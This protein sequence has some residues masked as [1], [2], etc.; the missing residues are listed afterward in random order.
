MITNAGLNHALNT[1]FTAGTP[2]TSWF[3]GL[4]DDAAFDELAETDTM[5]S[6]AGWT[7]NT[8][9]SQATRPAFSPST[10]TAEFVSNENPAEFTMTALKSLAGM[11]LTSV[12]TKGGTTGVLEL[13]IEFDT[14]QTVPIGETLKVYLE[15]EAGDG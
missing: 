6:H 11:F 5:G 14:V 1:E 9:Y 8:N 15:V 12:N 7:E 3:I 4:I 13:Q 10:A 2:V